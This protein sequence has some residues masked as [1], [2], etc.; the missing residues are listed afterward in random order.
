MKYRIW[1]EV[2]TEYTD[3]P[4]L[5]VIGEV[6]GDSHLDAYAKAKV[7]YPNSKVYRVDDKQTAYEFKDD[8]TITRGLSS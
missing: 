4:T 7:L 8:I 3:F 2:L 1:E 6:E 5:V